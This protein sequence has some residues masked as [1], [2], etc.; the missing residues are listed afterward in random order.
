[1]RILIDTNMLLRLDDQASSQ[2][3]EAMQATEGLQEAGYEGVLVPQ[4]LYEYWVVA[5]RPLKVNGLGLTAERTEQVIE[6]WMQL[7][8]L[9]RDERGVFDVWRTI[10]SRYDV[11]GK[12]SH[13]A[14][15]VAAM[16]KH[17]LTNL[18]TFNKSDFVR[19]PGIQVFTPREILVSQTGL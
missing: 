9:L 8:P 12:L 14:R 16:Q 3:A 17:G 18:L 10:V 7:F 19:F 11:K 4:V 15:L 5:T 6:G 2:H 1:M 13:D